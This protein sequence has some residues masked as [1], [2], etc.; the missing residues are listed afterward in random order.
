MRCLYAGI[1]D[2]PM[3]RPSTNGLSAV[4][5]WHLFYPEVLEK[6]T[7]GRQDVSVWQ[8]MACEPLDDSHAPFCNVVPNVFTHSCGVVTDN[9]AYSTYYLTLNICV[10][11]INA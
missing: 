5:Q 8:P 9:K 6:M 3:G 1:G 10:M 2:E 11:R 7:A 4:G